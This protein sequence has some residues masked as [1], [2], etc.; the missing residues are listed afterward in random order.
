M[1]T[2]GKEANF[3]VGGQFPVPIVQGGATSGAISV[4]F[5]DYGIKLIFTPHITSTATINDPSAP[6]SLHSGPW[7]MPWF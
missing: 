2:N 5:K 1:T 7:P 3:L 6:G 4:Q